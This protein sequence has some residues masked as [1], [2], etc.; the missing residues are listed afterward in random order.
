ML[1]ALVAAEQQVAEA[2]P[3][4]VLDAEDLVAAFLAGRS[5]RTL[6]AYA[7]DLEAFRAW[8]G[9]ATTAAAAQLLLAQGHGPANAVGLAYRAELLER[10]LAPATVNRRLASLRSL[11]ALAR[12]LGLVPWS[13]EVSGVRA[14]AYRDTRGPGKAGVRAL[15]AT[16]AD[17]EDPK[18]LRDQALVR[19]LHDLAL[20]RG[21][22][23]AL[24]LED[25][26][27]EA[28]TVA[29]LG[30]GKLQ[31]VLL[32]LPEPTRAALEAWVAVRGPEPGPLFVN[33]DR[34][35]K[36]GGRL[37][38]RSVARVVA[39]LG[40]EAGLGGV[41]PHGLRHAAITAALD[42]T[43]GDVRTVQRYSRHA[44]LETLMVYDD[45]RRDA[46]GQVAQ[47]VAAMA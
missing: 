20:R 36:G 22:A 39:S 25:V 12:T 16:A 15:L 19:V 21:E 44:K 29:V 28:G 5:P 30:K 11:V 18:G 26:D 14:E 47:L 6:R 45:S 2:V 43:G 10:G 24:D 35:G 9:A 31:K 3:A 23:V 27:F 17:R 13:L 32:T 8:T 42:A 37:S 7:A 1:T 46:A 33:F 40:A 34:A 41:R 4:V 38:G